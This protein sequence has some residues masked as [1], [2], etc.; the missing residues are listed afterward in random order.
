L[1]NIGRR[2]QLVRE[3]GQ[4]HDI[5]LIV[6]PEQVVPTGVCNKS[7]IPA[8]RL[9]VE[10]VRIDGLTGGV[11]VSLELGL[12]NTASNTSIMCWASC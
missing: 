4:H 5:S 9:N 1:L 3:H 12:K 2:D 8:Q 10:G 11:I 7:R 6:D